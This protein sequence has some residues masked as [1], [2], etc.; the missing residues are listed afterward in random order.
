MTAGYSVAQIPEHSE[1]LNRPADALVRAIQGPRPHKP[2]ACAVADAGTTPPGFK[3]VRMKFFEPAIHR[4][5]D[6]VV[7][8]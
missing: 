1:A 4:E 7:L 2:S 5:T 8:D 3:L 6:S